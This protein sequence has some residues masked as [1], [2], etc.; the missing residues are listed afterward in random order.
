MSVP[1]RRE[2]VELAGCDNASVRADATCSSEIERSKRATTNMMV[3]GAENRRN[4]L[5]LHL[6]REV[7]E[8]GRLRAKSYRGMGFPRAGAIAGSFFLGTEP[9]NKS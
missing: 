4:L 2:A 7:A 5:V 8:A 6:G 1:G 9:S 3:V